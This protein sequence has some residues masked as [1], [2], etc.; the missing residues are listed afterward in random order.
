MRWLARLREQVR[1]L[2]FHAREERD[3]DEEL[4]FHLEMESQ[5]NMG[6]GMTSAEASRRA[7]LSF[8]WLETHKD[9][10]REARGT[11]WLEDL[12]GDVRHGLR[13]LR[14]GPG[15]AAVVIVTL[16]VGIGAN[17]AVFSVVDGVLLRPL[18]YAESE[19]LFTVVG[20]MTARGEFLEVRERVGAFEGVAAFNAFNQVS[21]TGE[22][23][24]ERLS[25]ASVSPELFP[26]L[27]ATPAV[28]RWFAPAEAELGE[29]RVVLLSHGLW[30]RRFG[31]DPGVVGRTLRLDGHGYQVVGVM[32]PGFRFPDD[33]VQVWLPL[34]VRGLAPGQLWGTGGNY[35]IGRLAPGAT[36]ARARAEIAALAPRMREAVPWRMPD[37]YWAEVAVTPLRDALLGEVRPVLLILLGAVALLLLVACVNVAN[38][39]LARGA[40]RRG[41]LAV[42]AALGAGRG[43]ITRQLLAESMLL[44]L[45]GGTLGVVLAFGGVRALIATLPA[46]LPRAVDVGVDLRVLLFAL[47]ISL[48][49]GLLFGL[50]PALRAGRTRPASSFRDNDRSGPDRARQRVASGL[51]ASQVAAAVVLVIGAGLMVRSLDRL[52]E[53]DPGFN[54]GNV[55]SASVAP[56]AF[57]YATL[58]GQREFYEELLERLES[59]PGVL[60]A[61]VASGLPFAGD[62]YGSV[63]TIEGRP[64]PATVGGDWPWA[65]A[66]LTVSA[67]YFQVLGVPILRGRGFTH[68]DRTDSE[69]VV[70]VSRMLAEEYWPGEDPLGARVRFPGE[71]EWRT[72]VGI[73]GDVQWADLSGDRGTGLYIPLHQGWG[74]AMRVVLRSS[75]TS[76][77]GIAAVRTVVAGLDRDTPVSDLQPMT[78]LVSASVSDTRATSLLLSLFA[79]VALLLGGIGVYGVTSYAVSTRVREFG[80]RMALGATARQV[81]RQ[82]LRHATFVVAAGI[83]PG[84]LLALAAARLLA[85]LLFGI[86]A[87]D[88]ATFI[89]VPL[90]LAL[91]ALLAAYLP[92]RRAARVDPVVAI[93]SG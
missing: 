11:A 69:W 5:A 70:V 78:R 51:V 15:F 1:A 93:R 46:D 20:G 22:G 44:T 31:S 9:R 3:L 35:V 16:G 72:V 28:G 34:V 90:L 54:A 67:G 27:G 65:D 12:A 63:F 19:R 39:L 52:L 40:A 59:V 48:A 82:V 73:A 60:G 91:L 80:I 81:R 4:R 32:P 43:R 49:T 23:E 18:P 58:A 7:R 87:T 53:V 38:L 26:M 2:V 55:V 86:T 61:A 6:R 14:R 68:A 37:D 24:P 45:L 88:P 21:L 33:G 79:T 13:L 66:R 76:A 57:R 30:Q 75:S 85:G 29:H 62:A 8:G 56:P 89:A 42:R 74:G 84:L 25:A 41:E 50:A 10:V 64:D 77:A 83:V 47:V 36:E 17:V 71:E 92:A